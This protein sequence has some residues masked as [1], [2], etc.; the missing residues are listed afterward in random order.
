VPFRGEDIVVALQERVVEQQVQILTGLGQEEGVHVVFLLLG[1]D[2]PDACVPTIHLCM[3][4]QR[5]EH[6][7]PSNAVHG[8]AG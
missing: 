1:R 2:A 3:R 5:V 4:L 7:A 8:V 6:V